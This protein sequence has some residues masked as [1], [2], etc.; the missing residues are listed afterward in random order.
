M[1]APVAHRSP[2]RHRPAP[3]ARWSTRS[4][5]AGLLLELKAPALYPGIEADID[6]ALVDEVHARDMTISVYTLNTGRLMR[7]YVGLVVDGIIT[8]YPVVLRDILRRR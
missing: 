5:R 4:G 6:Q 3:S 8:D 1:H 7:E 2:R